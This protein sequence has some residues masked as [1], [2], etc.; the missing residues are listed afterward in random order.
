MLFNKVDMRGDESVKNKITIVTK[1]FEC[2]VLP[3][4]H[5]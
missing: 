5:F 2:R 3:Y 1:S 4:L